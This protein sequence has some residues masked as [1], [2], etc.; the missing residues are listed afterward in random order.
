MMKS[1]LMRACRIQGNRRVQQET[2]FR[3]LDW[4]CPIT[5]FPAQMNFRRRTAA[6]PARARHH[7]VH[8]NLDAVVVS[9][10]R[11]IGG[12]QNARLRVE[13]QHDVHEF[14][15]VAFGQILGVAACA[16]RA[17]LVSGPVRPWHPVR[18]CKAATRPASGRF[19]V[20]GC[21]CAGRGTLR[22]CG[23]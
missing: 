4:F 9:V 1:N 15:L 19:I 6:R 13:L 23:A 11:R 18:E 14:R 20:A 10:P 8:V 2:A 7:R 21:R 22:A 3:R 16:H 12:T 17:I 5:K